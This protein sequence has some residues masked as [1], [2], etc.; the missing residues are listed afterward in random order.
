MATVSKLLHYLVRPICPKRMLIKEDFRQLNEFQ[1]AELGFHLEGIEGERARKKT[2]SKFL[3][4][5][6]MSYAT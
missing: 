5:S 3:S 1:K 6:I 4:V 2:K